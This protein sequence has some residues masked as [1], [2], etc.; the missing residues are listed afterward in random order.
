M[1]DGSCRRCGGDGTGT[2]GGG[3]MR[4]RARTSRLADLQFGSRSQSG[5]FAFLL[6]LLVG[7]ALIIS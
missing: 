7:V 2:G 1:L 4:A 6:S 5:L 3:L